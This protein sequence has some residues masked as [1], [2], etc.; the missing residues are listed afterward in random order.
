M[1][2]GHRPGRNAN[3]GRVRRHVLKDDRTAADSGAFANRYSAQNLRSRAN[4]NT[5]TDGRVSLALLLPGAAERDAL[6]NRHVISH[7]CRFTDDYPHA[8]IDEKALA[9]DRTGV[10]LDPG[11]ESS[12]M[13]HET[14]EQV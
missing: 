10:D 14:R 13:G 5:I 11:Q 1:R 4:D 9:N 12:K 7:D 8:V 2:P 6:V 3:R